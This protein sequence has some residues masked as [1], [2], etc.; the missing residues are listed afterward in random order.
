[1]LKKFRAW[2]LALATLSLAPIAHAA[3]PTPSLTGLTGK[4]AASATQTVMTFTQS[5]QQIPFHIND[6]WNGTAYAPMISDANCNLQVGSPLGAIA[7]LGAS[8]QLHADLQTLNTTAG[9]PTKLNDSGGGDVSDPTNHAIVTE[10]AFNGRFVQ[11]PVNITTTSSGTLVAAQ[12]AGLYTYITDLDC[13]NHGQYTFTLTIT[14]AT[15]TQLYSLDVAAGGS[16]VKAFATPIGG[17]GQMATNTAI[18]VTASGG[19]G[20][21]AIVCNVQGRVRTN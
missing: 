18:S 16:F 20:N 5:A 3:C 13:S 17:N 1:M 6:V 9:N 8:G 10:P 12:G 21:P 11:A 2:A 19:T 15:S 4:D 14:N 7:D